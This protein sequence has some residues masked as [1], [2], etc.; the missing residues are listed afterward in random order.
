MLHLHVLEYSVCCSYPGD[1]NILDVAFKCAQRNLDTPSPSPWARTI[2]PFF[3][4]M[5]NRVVEATVWAEMSRLASPRAERR[6][7]F[8]V[9]WVFPGDLLLGCTRKL[10]N[11]RP[12]NL[13][14][15]LSTWRRLRSTLSASQKTDFLTLLQG[16]ATSD[17]GA[18][19]GPEVC[20]LEDFEKYLYKNSALNSFN[21]L[22]KYWNIVSYFEDFLVEDP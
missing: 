3:G 13:T 6:I 7:P 8:I 22:Q 15:L 5:Q 1:D 9:S 21:L 10:W 16:L 4:C 20:V 14:W 2:H 12:S 18:K 17:P 19:S 11:I